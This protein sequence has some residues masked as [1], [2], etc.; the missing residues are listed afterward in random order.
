MRHAFL[1]L[2]R[3]LGDRQ[4]PTVLQFN[5]FVKDRWSLSATRQNDLPSTAAAAGTASASGGGG[6]SIRIRSQLRGCYIPLSI[7]AFPVRL[8]RSGIARVGVKRVS[9]IRDL[10]AVA[11]MD[12]S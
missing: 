1:V 2:S 7:K 10:I 12:D 5:W 11:V 8:V 3:S 4:R 9:I 6:A